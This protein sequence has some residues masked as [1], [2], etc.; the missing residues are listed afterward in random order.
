MPKYPFGQNA[1]VLITYCSD[2]NDKKYSEVLATIDIGK[3]DKDFQAIFNT[4]VDTHII[5]RQVDRG[6]FDGIGNTLKQANPRKVLRYLENHTLDFET[7]N[8]HIYI[9]LAHFL[10]S[11]MNYYDHLRVVY[12]V[13]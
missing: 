11:I 6:K 8:T 2:E 10:A 9:G 3:A 4:N 5:S 12:Y 7:S 1:K 13:W